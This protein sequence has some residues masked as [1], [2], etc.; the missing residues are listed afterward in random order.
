MLKLASSLRTGLISRSI[1]TLAPTVNPAEQQ[2]VQAVLPDKLYS[3]VEI[4]Y[5]GHDKAVLKSY[6]SFLQ[7]F[8]RFSGLFDFKLHFSFIFSKSANT[9]RFLKVVSKFFRIFDGFSR[10]CARNSSIKNINCIM[11]REHTFLNLRLENN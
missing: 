4:E 3:S 5:R 8:E 1:R 2:Q 6:T 10:L 11:R 9:W 7:V